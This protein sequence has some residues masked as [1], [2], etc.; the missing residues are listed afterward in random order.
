M[1]R[2]FVAAPVV[3]TTETPTDRRSTQA[4]IALVQRDRPPRKRIERPRRHPHPGGN[5]FKTRPVS[6]RGLIDSRS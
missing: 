6:V 3:T 2:S 4:A 5:E 1:R